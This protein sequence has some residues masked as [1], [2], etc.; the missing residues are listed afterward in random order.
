MDQEIRYASSSGDVRIA[1]TASGRSSPILLFAPNHFTNIVEDWEHFARAP[2]LKGLT[3]RFRVVRMDQRGCG[4]STRGDLVQ[5]VAAWA[6]DI[7]AVAKAASP[8]QPVVLFALSQ[9]A[10]GAIEFAATRPTRV[11]HLVIVGGYARGGSE[12]QNPIAQ[13]PLALL[14]NGLTAPNPGFRMLLNAGFALDASRSDQDW[15]EASLVRAIDAG[16]L[17]PLVAAMRSFDVRNRL[18]QIAARTLVMHVRGDL[19]I[20]KAAGTEIALGVP[21]ARFVELPGQS[22]MIRESEGA[23]RAMFDALDAFIPAAAPR[24]PRAAPKELSRRERELIHRLCQGATNAA[25]AQDLGLSEKTVRNQLSRVFEKLG[26]SSRTQAVA[27]VLSER[28]G[29]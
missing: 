14:T 16:S 6:D 1:W 20:P 21:G 19:V 10:G 26:V 15:L 25:I 22:H 17:G 4:L 5:S 12:S 13:S 8:R 9:G 23:L 11:S 18:A 27:K 28:K 3:E 7:D 2:I 24:R 29:R